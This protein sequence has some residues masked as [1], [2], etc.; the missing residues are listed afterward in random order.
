LLKI[1]V[2]NLQA[3]LIAGLAVSIVGVGVLLC[4]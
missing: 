2:Q 3:L 1:S 4:T